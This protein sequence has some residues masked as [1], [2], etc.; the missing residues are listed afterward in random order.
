M[1]T[2]TVERGSGAG[3]FL[4]VMGVAF[5]AFVFAAMVG[6]GAAG[7]GASI[8]ASTVSPHVQESHGDEAALAADYIRR[9]GSHKTEK[10][11]SREL[12]TFTYNGKKWAAIIEGARIVTVFKAGQEYLNSVRKREGCTGGLQ[13]GSHDAPSMAW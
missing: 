13:L 5:A 10:C 11:G 12:W 2:T 6:A 9:G 4:L 3:L 1:T 7:E 8:R